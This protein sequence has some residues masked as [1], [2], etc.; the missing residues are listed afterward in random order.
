MENAHAEF[1]NANLTYLTG[2]WSFTPLP[3]H[4]I[5]AMEFPSH[6]SSQKVTTL[7]RNPSPSATV[8]KHLSPVTL[9]RNLSPSPT[10]SPKSSPTTPHYLAAHFP[11][12][13]PPSVKSRKS[14]V[15]PNYNSSSLVVP[16]LA[17]SR[18]EVQSSR[19]HS[20][21]LIYSTNNL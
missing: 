9:P 13:S 18:A 1:I 20:G 3:K 4:N 19:L 16:L 11:Q 21:I 14:P 10:H 5:R 15:S 8:P 2:I 12:N 7:P 6:L 17:Q